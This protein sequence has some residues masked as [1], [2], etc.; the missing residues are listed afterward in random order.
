MDKLITNCICCDK[1]IYGVM[2]CDECADE[3]Y[4]KL[5]GRK[6]NTEQRMKW[7]EK[8]YIM[9]NSFKLDSEFYSQRAGLS[10]LKKGGII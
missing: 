8:Y 9:D 4:Y 7:Y 1:L 6:M 2:F 3:Q 5:V 10:L